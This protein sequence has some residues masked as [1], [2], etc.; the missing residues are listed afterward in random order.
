MTYRNLF[1]VLLLLA[2]VSLSGA[3]HGQEVLT[4]DLNGI[5]TGQ[6]WT[7]VNRAATVTI[8][9]G[10]PVVSFD[11][12][13][14]DGA[15]WLDGVD[16]HNGTIEVRIRGK[17]VPQ[18]SFVGV[19]FRGVDDVTYDA[20]YFRP[21][22][23][24]AD[25]AL[26][27]SHH[28]QYISHPAH[29]WFTLRRDHTGVYENEIVNPPDPDGFFTARIEIAK[30]DIRVFVNDAVEPSLVVR[31]LTDRVAG[32]VGLWMGNGSDGAFAELVLRPTGSP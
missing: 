20:V 19:A 25:N 4:P 17:N 21:F 23:F 8:E 5:T 12:R 32:R 3:L 30:P 1:P 22:N 10:R 26:S 18:R 31:E 2:P 6:G 24:L 9:D 7:L 14:G 13:V 16:F 27:R 11:A 15:A 28:V 29:T